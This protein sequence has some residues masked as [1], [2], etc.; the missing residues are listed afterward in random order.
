MWH[1]AAG[2]SQ[3]GCSGC[4]AGLRSAPLSEVGTVIGTLSGRRLVKG[5]ETE[6]AQ[7]TG[8][9]RWPFPLAE[10][11][12]LEAGVA[13]S[14]AGPQ[15]VDAGQTVRKRH[16]DGKGYASEIKSCLII[17]K[18]LSLLTPRIPAPP[19][20]GDPVGNEEGLPLQGARGRGRDPACGGRGEVTRRAAPGNHPLRRQQPIGW[21]AGRALARLVKGT[22]CARRLRQAA[23]L[24]PLKAYLTDSPPRPGEVGAGQ[25]V[26][27]R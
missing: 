12:P 14:P 2:R 6:A 15:Q 21:L 11:R 26:A 9:A 10:R 3:A 24:Q 16:H 27:V 4:Q 1:G 25:L 8:V 17:V 18:G 20:P 13:H 23:R 5:S 19:R 22:A 7:W